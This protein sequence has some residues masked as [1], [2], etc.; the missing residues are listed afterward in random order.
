[1]ASAGGAMRQPVW[2]S[3]RAMHAVEPGN[4]LLTRPRQLAKLRLSLWEA[5]T[6]PRPVPFALDGAVGPHVWDSCHACRS[7]CFLSA[8]RACVRG[9][10]EF[11]SGRGERP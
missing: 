2:G 9:P 8:Q 4:V 5:W 1:K 10:F 6:E 7:I 11:G 3:I